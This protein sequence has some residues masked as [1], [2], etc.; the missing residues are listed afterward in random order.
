M[1]L[2]RQMSAEETEKLSDLLI[3][4]INPNSLDSSRKEFSK[5]RPSIF[6]NRSYW[7]WRILP[8][9]SSSVQL[10]NDVVLSAEP[11][12]LKSLNWYAFVTSNSNSPESPPLEITFGLS[13][14]TDSVQ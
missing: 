3:D 14:V 8:P 2:K 10:S 12:G 5:F 6:V 9:Q 13:D 7:A 4:E 11:F 1:V